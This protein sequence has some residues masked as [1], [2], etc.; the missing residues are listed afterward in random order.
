M[1]VFIDILKLKK[2]KYSITPVAENRDKI[3]CCLFSKCIENCID[4]IQIL[5]ENIF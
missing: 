2:L 5:Q 3:L 4:I 1:V